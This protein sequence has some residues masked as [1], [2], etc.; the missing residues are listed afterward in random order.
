MV[1]WVP[2]QNGLLPDWLHRHR[3]IGSG[4]GISRPS[5]SV[6]STGPSS[7]VVDLGDRGAERRRMQHDGGQHSGQV[8]VDGEP[9][10][11]E[12]LARS[13]DAEPVLLPDQLVLAAVVAWGRRDSARRLIRPLS[14]VPSGDRRVRCLRCASAPQP[15]NSAI[16][17]AGVLSPSRQSDADR[18][19]H[20]THD[21][22]LRRHLAQEGRAEA[23]GDRRYGVGADAE[24]PSVR[25]R[26]RRAATCRPPRLA[27][28][29]MTGHRLIPVIHPEG[30]PR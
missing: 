26:P 27:V 13:V 17:A 6:S 24:R 16:M 10:R 7:A 15:P 11:A 19:D 22:Q 9:R 20:P 2:S 14:A 4:C 1:R 21:G 25:G 3:F 18:T 12:D 5:T 23:D 30:Q 29:Q 28:R 8:D